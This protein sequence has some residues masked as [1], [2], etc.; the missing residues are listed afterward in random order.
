MVGFLLHTTFTLLWS[1]IKFFSLM[2]QF[3]ENNTTAMYVKERKVKVEER[4]GTRKVR[5]RSMFLKIRCQAQ[6]DHP[7][8]DED[9]AD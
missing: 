1:F 6:T 2:H 5:E 3:R 9:E 7:W 4:G 8:L